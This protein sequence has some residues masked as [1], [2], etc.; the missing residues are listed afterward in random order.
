M[1]YLLYTLLVVCIIAS[2]TDHTISDEKKQIY[3][4]S[5]FC[6]EDKAEAI[7]DINNANYTIVIDKNYQ[8]SNLYLAEYF[9]LYKYNLQI[10]SAIENPSQLKCY[11]LIMDSVVKSIHGEDIYEKLKR[12][13]NYYDSILPKGLYPDGYYYYVDSI[14][15]FQGGYDSLTSFKKRYGLRPKKEIN[16]ET[17]TIKAN[18][19]VILSIDKQGEIKDY[20][21]FLH[22]LP[23][24][25]SIAK[26]MI[27]NMPKWKP[28]K[29]G[30]KKVKYRTIIS[31]IWYE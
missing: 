16:N 1:K 30:N 10:K 4:D 23:E 31:F 8:F 27:E 14:A 20:R 24:Y 26:I 3:Y 19:D 7:K 25:D 17:S 11:K 18:V 5:L 29:I 15:E 13:V 2:C 9:L 22:D 28:A 12:K 21:F 6:E